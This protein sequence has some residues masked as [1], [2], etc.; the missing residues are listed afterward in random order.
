M[1]NMQCEPH[2]EINENVVEMPTVEVNII[3]ENENSIAEST[4]F[5]NSIGGMQISVD[6]APEIQTVA[7][8]S[9]NNLIAVT[10][11]ENRTLD[12]GYIN[13]QIYPEH[14]QNL[15][16]ERRGVFRIIIKCLLIAVVC[17]YL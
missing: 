1:I 14:N 11:D 12:I 13:P 4:T 6:S 7:E 10:S 15:Q 5:E 17:Y 8:E 9:I 2:T 3:D 16:D